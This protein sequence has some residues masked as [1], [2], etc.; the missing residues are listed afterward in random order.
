MCE[1]ITIDDDD[2]DLMMSHASTSAAA[3]AAEA[4]AA[5]SSLWGTVLPPPPMAPSP[6]RMRG[7]A[8]RMMGVAGGRANGQTG[9]IQPFGVFSQERRAALH[10][11]HPEFSAAD[12]SRKL[13]ELWHALTEPEKQF[14]RER[15]KR[16]QVR[17]QRGSDWSKAV[18]A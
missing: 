10:R 12:V 2:G 11:A 13:G 16:M 8:N 18:A 4:F 5:A 17:T 15:A 3:D 14:Y 6:G 1:V 9:V 7:V